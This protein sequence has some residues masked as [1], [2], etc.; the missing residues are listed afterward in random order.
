MVALTHWLEKTYRDYRTQLFRCAWQILRNQE[1]A[2]DAVHAAFARSLRLFECPENEKGYMMAAVRNAALDLKKREHKHLA[3]DIDKNE[4]SD[5]KEPADRLEV[6]L[7]SLQ[8]LKREVIELHLKVGLSFAEIADL[9]KEPVSTVTSRYR[10]AIQ[11]L[12]NLYG[13]IHERD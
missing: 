8:L 10:R 4:P 3:F 9:K 7:E 6:Q 11:E 5:W 2:E 13:V 12:K 1:Q